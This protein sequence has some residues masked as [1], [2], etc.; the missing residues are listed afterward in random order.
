MSNAE[1]L[2]RFDLIRATKIL[3]MVQYAA[4]TFIL[5]FFLGMAID[6][7]FPINE[8][9]E[10]GIDNY[11]L[12]ENLGLQLFLIVITSYYIKM[13]IN[14]VPVLI[15]LSNGYQKSMNYEDQIGISTAQAIMFIGVQKNFSKRLSILIDRFYKT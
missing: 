1:R 8:N 6:R 2:F 13:F 12:F 15:S 4:I 9:N 10:E 7:V 11:F 3:E 5:T 14:L